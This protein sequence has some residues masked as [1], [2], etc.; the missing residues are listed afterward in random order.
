MEIYLIASNNI[1]NVTKNFVI[2]VT[3]NY[4]CNIILNEKLMQQLPKRKSPRASWLDYNEGEYFITVCT[5]EKRHYFGE[6]IND[7]MIF[8]PIG[9]FLDEELRLTKIHHTNVQVL[10]S[11]VMPNHFHAIIKI[12]ECETKSDNRNTPT[13]FQRLN[14]KVGTSCNQSCIRATP[15][16]S[17]YIGQIK[18][19][20]T[21]YAH[22]NGWVFKWQPRYHDHAIRH[23]DEKNNIANYIINNV[24]NWTKDCFY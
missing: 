14:H 20:V 16:L 13:S 5:Y 23:L 2:P 11:T 15:L 1:K 22:E 19:A 8:S 9:K 21:R 6:I 17:T 7:N 12:D 4:F 10:V 24:T 18:A 3:K